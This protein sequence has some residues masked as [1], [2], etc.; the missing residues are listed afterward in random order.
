[1]LQITR[2]LSDDSGVGGI[3]IAGVPLGQKKKMDHWE[4]G[5]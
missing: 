1:M 5:G 3:V 2:L 4:T